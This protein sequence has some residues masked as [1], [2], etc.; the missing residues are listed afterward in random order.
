[1]VQETP[2]KII[3]R[4]AVVAV[5]LAGM[6][7]FASPMA[8]AA[9]TVEPRDPTSFTSFSATPNP[10][11][12]NQSLTLTANLLCSGSG[13]NAPTG[14]VSFFRGN[15][16]VTLL[17]TDPT[18]TANGTDNWLWSITV[19]AG[20]LPAGTST[21]TATYTGG[22]AAAVTC[23]G[24]STTTTVTIT[25]TSVAVS[26]TPVSP[27]AGS[28]ATLNATV[29]CTGD[30]VPTGTVQFSVNGFAVD[31]AV[32]VIASGPN[33]GTASV[34]FTFPTAGNEVVRA[35]YTSTNPACANASNSTTVLVGVQTSTTAL[36]ASTTTPFFLTPVVFTAIVNCSDAGSAAGGTVVFRDNGAPFATV[37]VVPIGTNGGIAQTSRTFFFGTHVVD[38]TFSG[39]ATCKAST[40]N[41][42]VVTPTFI[43]FSGTVGAPGQQQVAGFNGHA[44]KGV[45]GHRHATVS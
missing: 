15:P 34:P 45:K 23:T 13:G 7:A 9:G 2:G 40:S 30:S 6:A 4:L 37:P 29:T 26:T 31:G 33:S 19:P 17:G 27:T 10:A 38:A 8:A 22:T 18:P 16:A 3:R 41:T 21:L 11:S 36:S 39:T 5:A 14:T 32:P 43:P 24:T 20:T 12:P 28:P 25:S 1:V 35:D 44:D 42:V